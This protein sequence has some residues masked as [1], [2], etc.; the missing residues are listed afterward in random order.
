MHH[1]RK[2][3]ASCT[4]FYQSGC[5]CIRRKHF[6]EI[7]N[8]TTTLSFAE[9]S[10]K[11]VGCTKFDQ[12]ESDNMCRN[13]FKRSNYSLLMPYCMDWNA[14]CISDVVLFPSRTLFVAFVVGEMELM[15]CRVS[16]I[17]EGITCSRMASTLITAPPL[18]IASV[19]VF[20]LVFLIFRRFCVIVHR[21]R[22][23]MMALAALLDLKHF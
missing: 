14:A 3:I 16:L 11:L 4:T 17:G 2:Q 20:A 1:Q 6:K 12:S 8:H 10:D 18:T 21:H 23:I 7:K 5:D 9:T 19:C 22:S 15:S 13:R